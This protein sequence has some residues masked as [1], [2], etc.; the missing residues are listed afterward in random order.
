LILRTLCSTQHFLDCADATLCLG[1]LSRLLS[2]CDDE[3]LSCICSE[4]HALSY[5]TK[6]HH[7]AMIKAGVFPCLIKLINHLSRNVNEPVLWLVGSLVR[8]DKSQIRFFKAGDAFPRLIACMTSPVED[9]QQ[10]A[11]RVMRYVM[12]GTDDQVSFFVSK[13]CVPPLCHAIASS[14]TKIRS[15][16]FSGLV[17]VL[18]KVR[19]KAQNQPGAIVLHSQIELIKAKLREV[20]NKI[21]CYGDEVEMLRTNI[22]ID[23]V[24]VELAL[25][26][27]YC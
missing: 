20:E 22:N 19:S 27:G 17:K 24:R 2:S 4:F 16:A 10:A 14:H 12:S 18:T 8:G 7:E 15:H 23:L 25:I 11:C 21:E 3:L 13:G 1:P 5:S 6:R 26:D 9:T